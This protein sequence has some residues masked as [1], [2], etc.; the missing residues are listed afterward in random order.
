MCICREKD[1]FKILVEGCAGTD[2]KDQE[3]Y[4]VRTVMKVMAKR[5]GKGDVVPDSTGISALKELVKS[6]V[7]K[8]LMVLDAIYSAVAKLLLEDSSFDILNI[9]AGVRMEMLSE[10]E[11]KRVAMELAERNAREWGAMS[12]Q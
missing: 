4:L 3:S 12:A 8:I 2:R 1:E 5:Y 10:I 7:N 6:D 11:R 9:R